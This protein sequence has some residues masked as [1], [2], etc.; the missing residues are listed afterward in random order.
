SFSVYRRTYH[1][2]K[3]APYVVALIALDEGPRLVS[4]VVGCSLEDVTIGM[5]VRVRFEAAGAFVLPLFEP[6]RAEGD[7]P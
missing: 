5:R 3:P 7:R 4:N 1:P 6:E 2:G